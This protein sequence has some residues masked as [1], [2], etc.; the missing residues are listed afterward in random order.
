[1]VLTPP[2]RTIPVMTILSIQICLQLNQHFSPFSDSTVTQN[3]SSNLADRNDHQMVDATSDLTRDQPRPPLKP[4]Q[5]TRSEN[6]LPVNAT[7]AT[8][9]SSA[10]VNPSPASLPYTASIPSTTT[11]QPTHSTKNAF[12]FH[13]RHLEKAGNDARVQTA[14]APLSDQKMPS[15]ALTIAP[16]NRT[17]RTKEDITNAACTTRDLDTKNNHSTASYYA[18]RQDGNMSVAVPQTFSKEP[19]PRLYDRAVSGQERAPPSFTAMAPPRQNPIQPSSSGFKP[20]SNPPRSQ[21]SS[22]YLPTFNV[23]TGTTNPFT[24]QQAQIKR[25][26]EDPPSSA[27]MF[28]L[29]KSKLANT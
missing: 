21:N 3:D 29:K 19:V 7:L 25:G 22:I 20:L 13:S 18:P 10:A 16:S 11:L 23:S 24:V 15:S 9:T 28:E 6:A 26:P 14:A 2:P 12:P 8:S 17:S 4:V 1:M 27:S 5:Q